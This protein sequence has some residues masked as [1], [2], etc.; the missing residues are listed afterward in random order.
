MRASLSRDSRQSE[1]SENQLSKIA[2]NESKRTHRNRFFSRNRGGM[3]KLGSAEEGT[4]LDD[5]EAGTRDFGGMDM[6]DIPEASGANTAEH[7][8]ATP[9]SKSW[10]E[11]V[12]GE[13][14]QSGSN[15][16]PLGY[17]PEAS[18]ERGVEG[19]NST[20]GAGRGRRGTTGEWTV[21]I[22]PRSGIVSP[23]AV[24]RDSARDRG[25]LPK[26]ADTD[27]ARHR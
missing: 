24:T 21:R 20:E 5:L 3:G 26:R 14:M 12:E 15:R 27:L 2:S 7:S 19:R 23:Q 11:K 1:E 8:A 13:V 4:S 17:T 25:E 6:P 9:T 18:R 10:G 16:G 22:D